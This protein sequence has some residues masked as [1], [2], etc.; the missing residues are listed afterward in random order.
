M[1]TDFSD[2]AARKTVKAYL[3]YQHAIHAH[4]EAGLP[5]IRHALYAV[6]IHEGLNVKIVDKIPD[7]P[8]S[9]RLVVEDRLN[10]CIACVPKLDPEPGVWP[11]I[12]SGSGLQT[13]WLVLNFGSDE[14]DFY[15]RPLD[16]EHQERLW[17]KVMYPEENEFDHEESEAEDVW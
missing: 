3:A 16:E 14:P 12:H 13:D 6:L 11:A 1:N 5:W 4:A 2:W 8:D 17:E 10:I 15:P 9:G 7:Q